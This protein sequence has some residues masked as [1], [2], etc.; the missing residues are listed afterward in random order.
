[1]KKQ[2]LSFHD[3][4]SMSNCAFC[5]FW[6]YI[7]CSTSRVVVVFSGASLIGSLFF[8]IR[9]AMQIQYCIF[10]VVTGLLFVISF[11]SPKEM[12]YF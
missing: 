3:A 7:Y 5:H 10:A 8:D 11:T 1:M 4:L 9:R 12:Y 6:C 2:S